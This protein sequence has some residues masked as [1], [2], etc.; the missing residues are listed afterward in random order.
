M[1]DE[2]AQELIEAIESLEN[3]VAAG[4]RLIARA[5]DGVAKAI[6]ERTA[7]LLTHSQN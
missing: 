5:L 3:E 7:R 6:T 2:Q 4:S 1:D